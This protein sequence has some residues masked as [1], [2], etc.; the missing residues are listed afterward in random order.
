MKLFRLLLLLFYVS[1]LL[2]SQ[3]WPE[4]QDLVWS[5]NLNEGQ[6]TQ[7][8]NQRIFYGGS[9]VTLTT[10]GCGD[11]TLLWV[12]G[13]HGTGVDWVTGSA[14]RTS[15]VVANVPLSSITLVAAFY[16]VNY[17]ATRVGICS[18]TSPVPSYDLYWAMDY[19]N[20]AL[21]LSTSQDGGTQH[22]TSKLL[23]PNRW[24]ILHITR[25]ILYGTKYRVRLYIDGECEKEVIGTISTLSG[26]YNV[27][28]APYYFLIGTYAH[29]CSDANAF[30]K[31]PTDDV[32]FYN[33]EK[34]KTWVKSD[35]LRLLKRYGV[36]SD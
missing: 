3:R 20:G 26:K 19:I 25:G 31:Q 29:D 1:P 6:G 4:D 35:A 8:Q 28:T 32:S 21:E 10:S 16:P 18:F 2:A 34:D 30:S 12:D 15:G 14:L 7:A 33:V 27:Y 17:S 5:F 13:N 9:T 22:V 11:G 24:N 36:S 23:T